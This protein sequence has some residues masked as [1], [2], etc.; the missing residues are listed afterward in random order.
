MNAQAKAALQPNSSLA[1]ACSLAL[2]ELCEKETFAD[3]PEPVF[4]AAFTRKIQKFTTLARGNKYHR[5]TRTAKILIAAAII[6]LLLMLSAAAAKQF[7]FTLIN[8]GTDGRLEMEEHH[9]KITPL[10]YGYIPEGFTLDEEAFYEKSSLS[11]VILKNN[12]EQHI[13]ITK[14]GD[15]ES[16]SINTEGRNIYT[17]T[18]N[19]IQYTIVTSSSYTD[20]Y[21]IDSTTGVLYEIGSQLDV[22]TL[23]L[24]AKD[25]K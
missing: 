6:T 16:F 20:I 1:R 14:H 15:H 18:N 8:F 5:L 4:S 3:L 10:A 23:L 17:I 25:V 11:T 12:M 21:W 13:I 19:N 9:Q 22:D 7:G 24:I 2:L